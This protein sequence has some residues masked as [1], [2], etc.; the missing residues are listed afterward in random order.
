M[1]L[2]SSRIY[3]S[4]LRQGSRRYMAVI[5]VVP[6]RRK[7]PSNQSINQSINQWSKLSYGVIFM[8]CDVLFYLMHEKYQKFWLLRWNAMSQGHTLP[9]YGHNKFLL[10]SNCPLYMENASQMIT[11]SELLIYRSLKKESRGFLC[12]CAFYA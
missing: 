1:V 6:I 7:T 11:V 3:T 4:R 9:K 5:H 2:L 12:Y 8:F 10:F